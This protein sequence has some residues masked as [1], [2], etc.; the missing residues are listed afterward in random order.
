MRA[1]H[2]N[3]GRGAAMFFHVRTRFDSSN[4]LRILRRISAGTMSRVS[5]S[6]AA[7]PASVD[8]DRSLKVCCF[9]QIGMDQDPAGMSSCCMFLGDVM[10]KSYAKILGYRRMYRDVTNAEKGL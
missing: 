1:S 5:G 2:Q 4:F 3:P 10:V 7:S 8:N 6:L 9:S